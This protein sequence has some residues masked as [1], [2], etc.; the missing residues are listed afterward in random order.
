[1]AYLCERNACCLPKV[2]TV[3]L[4]TSMMASD[5]RKQLLGLQLTIIF[6]FISLIYYSEMTLECTSFPLA[7]GDILKFLV[8]A[9][10][11]LS[12]IIFLGV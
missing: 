1:M 5:G 8:V 11:G 10:K 6:F 3:N 12:S 4:L 9:E 2:P 7:K